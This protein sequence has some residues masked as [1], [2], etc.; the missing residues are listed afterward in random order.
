M[1]T[2]SWETAA[3]PALRAAFDRAAATWEAVL[4]LEIVETTGV[5]DW[6]LRDDDAYGPGAAQVGGPTMWVDGS[7]SA[8]WRAGTYPAMVLAHEIGHL[9]GLEH[10][11]TYGDDATMAESIMSYTYITSSAGAYLYPQEPGLKDIRDLAGVY[12]LNTDSA[13]DGTVWRVDRADR[14]DTVFDVGGQGDV[15]DLSAI[16]TG[17]EV[18]M[19]TGTV[20]MHDGWVF[21]AGIEAVRLSS[22]VDTVILSQ[23]MLLGLSR[24]DVLIGDGDVHKLTRGEKR[25][26]GVSGKWFE[27][28]GAYVEWGGKAA[29]LEALIHE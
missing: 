16:L 21:S 9:L 24:G 20:D 13:G 25:E 14:I 5:T 19:T 8:E 15:L 1:I 27:V 17:C 10:P 3:D 12:G 22:G 11:H 26:L 18:D 23:G 28:D 2:Y 7:L 6:R 4:D 29:K